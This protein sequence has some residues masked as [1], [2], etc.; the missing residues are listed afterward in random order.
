MLEIEVEDARYWKNC[1]DSIVNLI[2]EGSFEISANGISLKAMDPSQIAMVSFSIPKS[3]F[4]K[5]K[6]DETTRVGINFDNMSKILSRSRGKDKLMMMIDENKLVLEFFGEDKR[7]FKL[8]LLDVQEGAQKEPK[9]EFDAVVKIKAGQFKE[10]LGDAALLSSHVVL[11]ASSKGFFVEV[12]GDSG[13]LRVEREKTGEATQHID[14]KKDSRA[15]FPLQFM[16]DIVKACPDDGLLSLYLKT[17]SPIKTEYD[18][19]EAKLVYYL[20][21]RIESM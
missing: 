5:Y 15:T 10:I 13:D 1:I 21:P 11:E 20:A 16:E 7:N 2:D 14:V 19:G 12:H 6:V 3:A 18:I 8:P 9:I 17:N 4:S